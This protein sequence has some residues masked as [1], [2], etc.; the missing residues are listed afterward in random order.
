MKTQDPIEI[1]YSLTNVKNYKQDLINDP[2]DVIKKISELF[3]EYFKL[4]TEKNKFKKSKLFS[5]IIMRGL[6]TIINVFNYI[7]LYTKNVDITYYH[8]QKAFYFYVEFI[9]QIFDEDKLFLHLSSRDATIY[10]YKK[11]IFDINKNV[12]TNHK[13]I[14]ENMRFKLDTIKLYANLYKTFLIKLINN[15]NDIDKINSV[16]FIYNKLNNFGNKLNIKLATEV[17]E[18]LSYK[19]EDISYFLNVCVL[20]VEKLTENQTILNNCIKNI[21]SE[22]FNDKLCET[23][24]KFMRWL[25]MD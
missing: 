23:P 20:L 22:K 24:D 15:F 10:V 16:E 3:T 11:T 21:L 4:I 17:I 14:T 13:E 6:D 9:E 2:Y 12:I 5:F 7:L 25:I 1:N 18:H 19:I 8:S